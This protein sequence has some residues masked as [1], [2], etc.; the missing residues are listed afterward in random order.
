MPKFD[1]NL[2]RVFVAIY[3]TSSVTLAAD[4]LGVTQP[5]VSYGLARLREAY[6]DRL[7]VR[8]AG[9]LVATPRSHELHR[10]FTDVLMTVDDSL[11]ESTEF[12]PDRSHRR[13]K[14]AMSDIGEL[15][16]TP[17]L[18]ARFSEVAPRMELEVVQ[19]AV[20][21]VVDELAFG[22][23]DAAIGNLPAVAGNTR[24]ALLFQERYVCLMAGNHPT[25][26]SRLSLKDYAAAR[27]IMVA[28]PYTGHRV[29]DDVLGQRDV[30][31][32][33]AVRLPHFTVLPTLVEQSDLLV[34]LP[35]RI[36]DLYVARHAL[37]ALEL[38]IPIPAFEVRV[39]WHQRHAG[40][41]FTRWLMEQIVDVLGQL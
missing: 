16:F 11:A 9:Q 28:S 21:Q 8:G 12:L 34:T 5:T 25:I 30:S 24:S 22:K 35:S 27:H 33:I 40:N 26:G 3:E 4:R 23:I 32:H 17:P 2:L 29:V 41:A 36:A 1:L 14:L 37:K 13:V 39:Y 19:A 15:Y 18:L 31:R 38:P 20:D 6:G 7:F 10:Q